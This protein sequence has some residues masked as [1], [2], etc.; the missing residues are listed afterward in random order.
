MILYDKVLRAHTR[1][2]QQ[3]SVYMLNRIIKHSCMKLSEHGITMQTA[4]IYI[5][6]TVNFGS[7][8]PKGEPC[9]LELYVREN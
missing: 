7:T 4:M 9:P 6:M 5:Q 8:I 2:F 1:V 3:S